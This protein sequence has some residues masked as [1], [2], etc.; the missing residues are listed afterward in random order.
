MFL[1]SAC[2]CLCTIYW[3]QVLSGEWRCSW[4]SADRR[5]SNYIWVINN[6]SAYQGAP[7]IRDLTVIIS[8]LHQ[9]GVATSF[10]RNKDITITSDVHW[11]FKC[12]LKCCCVCTSVNSRGIDTVTNTV[13]GAFFH[14]DNIIW[15]MFIVANI[16]FQHW[17]YAFRKSYIMIKCAWIGELDE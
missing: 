12:P 4:S 1:N 15:L 8:L 10:W 3:S 14:V 2:S 9:N 17:C 7:Y 5:C 13:S 11:V 16:P 6:L